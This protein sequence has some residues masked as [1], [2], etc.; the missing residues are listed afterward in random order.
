[1]L[2]HN[3]VEANPM[4]DADRVSERQH[5]A[6][7][8][9]QIDSNEVKLF[10][11]LSRKRDVAP[12]AYMP[13]ALAANPKARRLRRILSREQGRALEMIGHAVDYLNDSCLFEGDDQE[14]INIGGT[15]SEA[16]QIL[17][18]SRR[19]I[20]QCAPI[21]EPRSARLWNALFHR[22]NVGRPGVAFHRA[23]DRGSQTKPGSV[24]PLSSSR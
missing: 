18:S 5:P 13:M 22:R 1:M 20:L 14:L 6:E 16:I 11:T 3:S 23:S 10:Q 9:T 12:I 2:D 17:V 24:L 19:Q 15:S 8:Q 4:A 21:R 7:A